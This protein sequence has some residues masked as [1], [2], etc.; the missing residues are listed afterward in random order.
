M[1]PVGKDFVIVSRPA[2]FRLLFFTRV[3]LGAISLLSGC[4]SSGMFSWLQVSKLP[5]GV[6]T[7]LVLWEPEP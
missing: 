3:P 2:F 1:P 6:R 5:T 7:V 4:W